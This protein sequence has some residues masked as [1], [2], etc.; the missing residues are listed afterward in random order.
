MRE[1]KRLSGANMQAIA[2]DGPHMAHL[3]PFFKAGL[4]KPI[5]ARH[6]GVASPGRINR[7]SRNG[8]NRWLS[9]FLHRLVLASLAC[10][11][12]RQAPA[13]T[14]ASARPLIE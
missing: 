5:P 9:I 3:R 4:G 1:R 11:L 2:G 6:G 12:N 13:P 10:S 8:T 7:L 14:P